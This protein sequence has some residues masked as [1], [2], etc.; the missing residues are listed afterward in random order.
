MAYLMAG[1]AMVSASCSSSRSAEA[2]WDDAAVWEGDE[3]NAGRRQIFN[4]L[5]QSAINHRLQQRLDEE[6]VLLEQALAL[7]PD[8]AEAL[9]EMGLLKL[10][11]GGEEGYF[12]ADDGF[13]LLQ[14]AVRLAPDNEAY[15]RTYGMYCAERGDYDTAIKTY[16]GL[17]AKTPTADLLSGLFNF[18]AAAKRYGEALRVLDRMELLEGESNDIY[19]QRY[20]IYIEMKDTARAYAT[21]DTLCAANAGDLYFPVYKANLYHEQGYNDKALALYKKVLEQDPGNVF[22]KVSL[23]SFYRTLSEDEL[24]RKLFEELVY[25]A[26]TDTETR[27]SVMQSFFVSA[28]REKTDTAQVLPVVRKVLALPQENGRLCEMALAYMA[29]MGATREQVLF[30][31]RRLLQAEPENL[32]ASMEVLGDLIRREQTP[33]VAEL[34]ARGRTYHPGKIVFYIYGALAASEKGQKDEAIRIL[35]E[36]EQ[37]VEAATDSVSRSEMIALL[38][39]LY[40]EKGQVEAAFSAYERAIACNP[41]N[42][43]CL[44]NFAYFLSQEQREL[45]RAAEMSKRT[46]EAEP[47]NST[48]LDTYAWILYQQEL[49]TQARIYIDETLK[50]VDREE[51]NSTLYDHAGDIYYRCGEVDHAVGFWKQALKQTQ[52]EALKERLKEKIRRRKL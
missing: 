48:Y 22:A 36:G 29:R 50:Y 37:R 9:Y 10:T 45:D 19:A 49:Y 20:K 39:D 46:V 34:C 35:E 14:K 40:H 25:S 12:K 23:L 4:D 43:L 31:Q 5:Y 2:V 47:E 41:D 11:Y 42:L 16:E 28:L 15:Q 8:A 33:E 7:C 26:D 24:Y 44:N 30:I 3:M 52:D 38:G 32:M 6:Y 51:D 27:E 18:Y 1:W 13:A 17:V 21:I